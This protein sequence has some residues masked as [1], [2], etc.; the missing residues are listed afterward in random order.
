MKAKII[1]S[2]WSKEVKKAMIDKDIDANDIAD[3]FHWTKQYTYRIINGYAYHKDAV[4]LISTYLN[5]AIPGEY[6]TLSKRKI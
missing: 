6:E 3:R 4:Q 1:F 2:P 5:I